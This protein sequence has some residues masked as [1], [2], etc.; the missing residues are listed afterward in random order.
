M[1]ARSWLQNQ[2]LRC[3]CAQILGAPYQT[4][5]NLTTSVTE[6]YPYTGNLQAYDANNAPGPSTV[7]LRQEGGLQ[8]AQDGLAVPHSFLRAVHTNG[9]SE[10]NKLYQARLR[11][12]LACI[13]A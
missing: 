6:Y 13:F 1:R 5:I 4:P 3:A 9:Y 2:L 12:I 10:F 7:Y 8:H 11:P